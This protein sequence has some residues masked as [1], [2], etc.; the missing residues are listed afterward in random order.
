MQHK[1][2]K[3]K[4]TACPRKIVCFRRVIVGTLQ[5]GDNKYNNNNNNNNNNKNNNNKYRVTQKKGTFE[6]RNKNRRNPR[7]KLIDRN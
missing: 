6:K 2:Y 5:T 3:Q 4:V 1:L 7:K